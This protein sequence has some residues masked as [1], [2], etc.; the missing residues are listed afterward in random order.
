MIDPAWILIGMSHV[1]SG[2]TTT[3]QEFENKRA[4]DAG[5]NMVVAM[6]TASGD[7]VRANCISKSGTSY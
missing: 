2:S 5:M 7:K 3:F 1:D 6:A 4:C